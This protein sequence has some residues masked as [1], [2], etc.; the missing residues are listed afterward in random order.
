VKRTDDYLAKY[1]LWARE[2]KVYPLPRILALPRFGSRRFSSYRE[3]N[4]WKRS[5]LDEVARTGGVRWTK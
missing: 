1:E 4:D 5:L 2:G 3:L